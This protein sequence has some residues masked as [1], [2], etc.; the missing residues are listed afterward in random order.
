MA[1]NCLTCKHSYPSIDK[2]EAWCSVYDCEVYV[3]LD[4][5][6]CPAYKPVNEEET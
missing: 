5:M 4:S 3:P 1:E 6:E 2:R